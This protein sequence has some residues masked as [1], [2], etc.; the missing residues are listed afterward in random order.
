MTYYVYIMASA[1]RVL[2]VGMTNN[3]ERRAMGH[4]Q[5][6]VPSFSAKYKTKELVYVEAFGDVR[7]AIAREKQL[8]G[9]LRVKKIALI[10]CGNPR[11]LDLSAD[12]AGACD[13]C[14][15]NQPPRK[16]SF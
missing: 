8:K 4:R 7:A 1:S 16:L 14:A 10:K 3:I 9:W 13:R 5:G 15:K 6:R 11:W 2:Y 12:W